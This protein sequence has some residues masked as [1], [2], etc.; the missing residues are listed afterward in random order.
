M[1]KFLFGI[2]LVFSSFLASYSQTIKEKKKEE[3]GVKIKNLFRQN[4]S[5]DVTGF[6][7]ADFLVDHKDRKGYLK[8]ELFEK[9][10]IKPLRL[11]CFDKDFKLLSEYK[12]QGVQSLKFPESEGFYYNLI[13]AGKNKE[14]KCS[15]IV[16]P[17]LLPQDLSYSFRGYES[18]K[19]AN[20]KIES[21]QKSRMLKD[22]IF[23]K[24]VA[25]G[26]HKTSFGELSF[27]SQTIKE[28]KEVLFNILLKGKKIITI[29]GS[30]EIDHK[31][32]SKYAYMSTYPNIV[33]VMDFNN[34]KKPD[35]YII[36]GED[37]ASTDYSFYI[38]T[39]DDSYREIHFTIGAL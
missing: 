24:V 19:G 13:T 30:W 22:I 18:T 5:G 34:D 3:A 21:H 27:S 23:G 2:F 14:G 1:M 35:F 10:S 26:K 11:A 33:S 28:S 9:I 37:T 15:F 8:A 6:Y 32:N 16:F 31:D 38:S 7:V 29:K 17:S 20:V 25:R 39:G 36:P 12:V 4:S